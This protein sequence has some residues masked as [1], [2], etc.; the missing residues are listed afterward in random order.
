MTSVMS[1]TH[2]SDIEKDDYVV[3]GLATCFVR[4]DGEIQEVEVM[5]PVPS[6]SLEVLFKGIATS[7]KLVYATTVGNLLD[8]S[9]VKIPSE[10]P[11]T[12]QLAEDF[13]ER[14]F[15][16]VRT[17]KR[18]ESAKSLIQLGC[19]YRELQHSTERKRVLNASRT[20][21][22]EDNVKQHSHTHK[23]L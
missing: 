20:V 2:D 7:Y 5:E 12:V 13:E 11:Q 21:K 17:Y 14:V 23:V 22:T 4:E 8:G 10:F 1:H 3:I 9:T 15:A 6:A 18:K 16:A 19:S